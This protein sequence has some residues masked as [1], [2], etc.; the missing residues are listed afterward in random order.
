MTPDSID[1]EGF[2]ANVGIILT[3]GEGKLMIAGRAGRSGWQFPQ[4]GVLK[5][6]RIEDALYRE[7][8]EE[9]GLRPQDVEVLAQT[10][11]WLRY[12]LPE[13]YLRRDQHPLCIGQKQ[14]WFMLRLVSDT[15]R[16]RFD[17]TDEPEFD[18]WRWVDYWHPVKEV[19]YFKRHVYVKA[20]SELKSAA[21]P[22]QQ[23][24]SPPNWWPRNWVRALPRE[25]RGASGSSSL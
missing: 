24:P 22:G 25:A 17:S 18:R 1:S 15:G 11:D 3:D 23:A 9:V 13:R 12:R 6:E 10:R 14:R 7:L 2:R 5:D 21:F 16:L 19:V 8:E 4:G 20:L